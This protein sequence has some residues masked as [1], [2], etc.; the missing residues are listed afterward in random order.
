MLLQVTVGSI[1][2]RSVHRRPR[3]MAQLKGEHDH[4]IAS[5]R[6]SAAWAVFG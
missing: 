1:E 3:T 2:T 4:V 5:I 6:Y